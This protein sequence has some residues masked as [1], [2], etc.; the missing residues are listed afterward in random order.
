MYKLSTIEEELKWCRAAFAACPFAELAW[1]IHHGQL[2]EK[3]SPFG[4]RGRI[5]YILENKAEDEQAIRLA[6]FRPVRV[7]LPDNVAAMCLNIEDR[8]DRIAT[9]YA[10]I[11]IETVTVDLN[12]SLDD[13]LQQSM[14]GSGWK[15]VQSNCSSNARKALN[16]RISK[17][18]EEVKA[19]WAV[20]NAVN[21]LCGPSGQL[22][23][24]HNA[25]WPGNSWNGTSIFDK[26]KQ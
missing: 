11:M 20:I 15:G 12:E 16:D 17:H 6:N 8:Q 10:G 13:M 18:N 19:M 4:A 26:D 9:E 24:L 25:D 7:Q 14:F 21:E 5:I 1:C 22:S 2:V 23:Q 3:L